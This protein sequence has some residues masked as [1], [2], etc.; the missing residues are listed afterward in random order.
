MSDVTDLGYVER[1]YLLRNPTVADVSEP[2]SK[3]RGQTLDD[4][5]AEFAG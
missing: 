3:C 5:L 4:V 1:N 2:Q